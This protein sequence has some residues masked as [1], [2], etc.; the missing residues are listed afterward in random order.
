[1]RLCFLP[2]K[3]QMEIVFIGDRR[4]KKVFVL[5]N[6]SVNI[7]GAININFPALDNLVSYLQNDQQ[8]QVDALTTQVE[9]LTSALSKSTV[10]LQTA[11][12]QIK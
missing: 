2:V 5:K 7:S 12:Q 10:G 3:E 9:T 1:M 8:R 4:I 6:I 11:E